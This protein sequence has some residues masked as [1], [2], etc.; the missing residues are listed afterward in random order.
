MRT[1][2]MKEE[3]DLRETAAFLFFIARLIADDKE[4]MHE[5]KGLRQGSCKDENEN[6]DNSV[7]A[8]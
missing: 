5:E 2:K 6:P 1:G 7:N 4:I 8:A 3:N